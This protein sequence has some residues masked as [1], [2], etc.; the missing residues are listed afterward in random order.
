MKIFRRLYVKVLEPLIKCAVA[1]RMRS[2]HGTYVLNP[3][4]TPFFYMKNCIGHHVLLNRQVCFCGVRSGYIGDYSYLGSGYIYDKVFIGKFCSIAQN[5]TLGPGNHYLDRIST[6]PVH[7]RT[8]GESAEDFPEQQ[9][10][11]IGNDVWIG[12]NAVVM[13]GVTVGDG[14]VI[15]AGCVVTKDVP[16]YAVMV[17]CPGRILRYR[18]P[19]EV[20]RLLLELRW[21]DKDLKWLRAHRDVFSAHAEDLYAKLNALAVH[22]NE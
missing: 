21:W 18:H 8:L 20:R 3:G 16:P 19:E 9:P 10:T 14:A 12:N 1:R 6:Y 5:V 15:A 17:G 4:A 11:H 22:N 2:S 13:Q 7:I